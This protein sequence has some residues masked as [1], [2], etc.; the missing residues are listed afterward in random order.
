MTAALSNQE[1]LTLCNISE[2]PCLLRFWK[3][4]EHGQVTVQRSWV[5]FAQHGGGAAGST[6]EKRIHPECAG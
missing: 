3:E 1:L 5:K 6:W 4:A 2:L